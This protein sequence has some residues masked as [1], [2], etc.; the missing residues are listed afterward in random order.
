MPP[1]NIDALKTNMSHIARQKSYW[2]FL[3]SPDNPRGIWV[4]Y[5]I[6]V[7]LIISAVSVTH[8]A[9]KA[10]IQEIQDK[11]EAIHLS[12]QQAMLSQRILFLGSHIAQNPNSRPIYASKLKTAIR[13]FKRGHTALLQGG[14]LDINKPLPENLRRY[15]F[16]PRNGMTLDE[17]IQKF[18]QDADTI[19]KSQDD[20]VISEALKSLIAS[21]LYLQLQQLESAMTGYQNYTLT[22]VDYIQ[23]IALLSFL[24][25]LIILIFEAWFIFLPAHRS[26]IKALDSAEAYAFRLEQN[27]ADLN[28]FAYV[29]SHDLMAPLRGM[30]NLITWV[31]EDMPKTASK[32]VDSYLDLLTKRVDRMEALLKDILNFS[33][34][35]KAPE[36][37]VDVD[38]I[39]LIEELKSWIKIPDGFEVKVATDIPIIRAPQTTLQQCFLNLI[40]N[41]IKHHDRDY[42]LVEVRYKSEANMHV[43]HIEDDGPGI[44]PDYHTYVFEMFNRLKS[45]DEVE[46]SG[47]GLA[48]IKRMT[49]TIGGTIQ[50]E[51]KPVQDERGTCFILKL[52]KTLSSP[53]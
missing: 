28:H 50:L 49:E 10:A 24:L 4:R 23:S 26:I 5:L 39:A 46:G 12:G 19:T 16:T 17:R 41:G 48:I 21:G 2:A 38:V 14:D 25:A 45:R 32:E 43:F 8:F 37:S 1:S 42:G 6:A 18:A 9:P 44:P 7:L 40:S 22:K 35:G 52:P 29:A 3:L 31:K 33:R 15:Y 51:P 20:L 13:D 11:A 36:D 27:N 47:I 34:A 53:S 30:S